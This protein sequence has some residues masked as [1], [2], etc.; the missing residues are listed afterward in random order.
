MSRTKKLFIGV[1]ATF[2]PAVTFAQIAETA[3]A[4]AFGDLLENIL[5][6]TNELLI[7]FIIGIGFLFFVWGMFLYFI[8]GGASEEKREKGKGLM[9]HAIIGF[10]VIIIFFGVINLLTSSTGLEGEVIKNVPQV[11]VP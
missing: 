6:V 2:S 4:G 3:D 10:V 5:T 1:L 11:V 7:P 9:I 8:M